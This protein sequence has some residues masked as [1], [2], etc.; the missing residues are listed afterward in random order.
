MAFIYLSQFQGQP[1]ITYQIQKKNGLIISVLLL[2][3]KSHNSVF[4][5][6]GLL[7]N[8]RNR[9]YTLTMV[10]TSGAYLVWKR[11]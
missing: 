5:V 1:M 11:I 8:T 6:Y 9:Y 10:T 7:T 3:E 2:A 4:L